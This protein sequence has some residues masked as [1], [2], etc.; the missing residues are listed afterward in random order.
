MNWRAISAIVRKDVAL[1]LRTK[2]VAMPLLIVP[3]LLM[4]GLPLLL[5]G[6]VLLTESMGMS[7]SDID[8]LQR[9]IPPHIQP[10]L[11]GLTAAQAGLVFVLVYMFAPLFLIVPLM[12]SSVVAADSFAG[13]KERK[14]LE[15][16]AY[17][18]TT[19]RELLLA[20]MLGGWIP[21]VLVGLLGFVLYTSVV[22]FVTWRVTGN[23]Y[24]PNLF[25]LLLAF[26]VGPAAAGLGLGVTVLV[27]ARVNTFQE[28]YQLGSLVVLPV[29]FLMIGQ[30]SGLFYLNTIFVFVIGLLLWG[31]NV[32][33]FFLG[34][35]TFKRSE[36][37]ARLS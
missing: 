27:S 18:P 14:T 36:L 3:L 9:T 6:I 31:I 5:G 7:S 30:M 22:D 16:L 17:T 35:A 4:V 24:L 15:A 12:V 25:W 33:L 20:K 1:A 23:I 13:E 28:A 11:A 19:D 37:M 34:S 10:A 2:A 8:E 32:V 26:W 29:V 21:G